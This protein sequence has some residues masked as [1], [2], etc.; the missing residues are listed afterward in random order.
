MKQTLGFLL[1][2]LWSVTAMAQEAL[3]SGKVTDG[4]DGSSLPGVSVSIKGTT[5]GTVT[6]MDGKY[7]INS[8]NGD[9][10]IFSFIGMKTVEVAV[11]GSQHNATMAS[12][13]TDLDDVVVVGY[14][15]QKKKLVVGANQNVKGDAI[16]AL[17]TPA[18]MEA[19]QGVAPGVSITRSSG[20]PTA[21][22][23]VTIRGMGTNGNSTPLYI[24]DGVQVGNIDFL[25]TNDI[26]SIDVLKD[27]ASAAIYGSRAA[28]GVILVTTKKGKKAQKATITYDGYYG[29]QNV[30]KKA[31][32]LNAQQY[33]QMLDEGNV[34]DGLAP[35]DW[36]TMLSNN[37]WLETKNENGN[38]Y[39]E[40]IWNN[41]QNGWEGTDW[42][43]EMTQKNA[44]VKSH[45]INVNG[46]SES[47]VYNFG[48]SYLD[49]ASIVGGD[50][51]DAGAKKLTAR[52]NTE[53]VLLKN[54]DFSILKFGENFAFTQNKNRSVA[55]GNIYWNDIHNALV[56]NPLM[57]AYSSFSNDKYG[58]SNSLETVAPYQRNPLA[59]MYY[60][61]NFGWYTG[62]TVVGNIYAELQVVKDLVLRSSLGMNSWY[63]N[64]RQYAPIYENGPKHIN[65]TDKVTQSSY[66]GYSTIWTNTLNY[67]K[68]LGDHK[69]DVLIGQEVQQDVQSLNLDASMTGLKFNGADYAYI[70][71][72]TPTPSG[73]TAHGVDWGAQGGGVLSYMSRAQYDYKEKYI[74]SGTLRA[75]G[76][77][78][79]AE[80]N[81]W[82]YF[83]SV[84]AGWVLTSEEFM[85]PVADVMDFAKL[86]ASWG[87]N[88][89]EKI[90]DFYYSSTISYSGDNK[91][92][93]FGNNKP[94][95]GSTS[96]PSVIP[97]PDVTWETSEQYNFGIDTRFLKSRLG[98]TFD[99]YQKNTIDLL[100]Y[101]QQ[102]GTAGAGAPMVNAGDVRNQ[103]VEAVISWNDNVADFKY[104]ATLSA[105]SNENKVT[106]LDNNSGYIDGATN[107]L[108][109]GTG[110]ISRMSVGEPMGYFYGY[111]TDGIIQNQ[112]EADAYGTQVTFADG[113]IRP[114]DVRFVDQNSDGVIDE[115]DKVKIG[116]P[117]PKFE[118]G[119]QL[120]VEYKGIY[121]NATITGKYG[122]QVMQSYRSFADSPVQNYTTSI[123]D[124]WHGEGT[125]NSYPRLSSQPNRNTNYVSDIY[126]HDADYTRIQNVTIGYDLKTLLSKEQWLSG[127]KIYVSFKNLYTF[128]SYD[129]MDPEVGYSGN[130]DTNNPTPWA[131]GVDLGLFP[132]P[133]T[134]LFGV[135][136]AF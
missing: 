15:V 126:M 95:S 121:A 65:G 25:S 2:L 45:S 63:G 103:G 26:E 54:D 56:Q 132:Q 120:N 16:T 72:A 118:L 116:S 14:G 94:T 35:F 49:Q 55:E 108:S 86:R 57:P 9:V 73:V 99:W 39:G 62:N 48:V 6:D 82:G 68:K 81:Q 66:S 38:E 77:S 23:N 46:G 134:V 52:L 44:P 128:T 10:L 131:S 87:Q 105:S 18:A 47:V 21:G 123:F 113:D 64:G 98:F 104:G 101:K 92:Y 129:G 83:P 13:I 115:K 11:T 61:D 111:K 42:V 114:G 12:D 125:S 19:L 84:A 29:V 76:S 133:R 136:L 32:A 20:S 88:G 43:D 106:K 91:G 53:F 5:N 102:P 60:N 119:F 93:V 122:M 50:L 31:P 130:S 22:T 124:R 89:N 79:F 4:S 75:D 78:H 36:Q 112:D 34:N 90:G 37:P 127:A 135:N 109:Q 27:A 117:L 110:S 69:I 85:S 51:V 58:F 80:G 74:I 8:K 30:Y 71:N 3:V 28:N 70:N 100:M 41:L 96:Y 1:V 97:N 33:M 59:T 17:T 67:K 107:V 40:D 7:Q 24:V